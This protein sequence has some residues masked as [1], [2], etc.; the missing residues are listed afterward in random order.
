MSVR[1]S[2]CASHS[3][4]FFFSFCFSLSLSSLFSLLLLSLFL[5]LSGRRHPRQHDDGEPA[6]AA[7]IE[8][9]FT[10]EELEAIGRPGDLCF[11]HTP[12]LGSTRTSV[13]VGQIVTGTT[14]DD[15]ELPDEVTV[16]WWVVDRRWKAPA[17]RLTQPNK[18]PVKIDKGHCL[19]K[20]PAS[21]YTYE[22][23]EG[24]KQ[25]LVLK[26]RAIAAFNTWSSCYLRDGAPREPE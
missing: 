17:L 5:H 2:L 13:S 6:A 11:F 18:K 16:T 12:A 1:E 22:E 4:T 9:L 23:A 19:G 20:I 10:P 26:E 14:E 24:R 15:A 8:T 3:H 21:D 7:E 25:T